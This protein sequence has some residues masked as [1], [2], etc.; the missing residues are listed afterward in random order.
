[1]LMQHLGK[2]NNPFPFSGSQKMVPELAKLC[3]QV[4]S[5]GSAV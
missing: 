3:F 5:I 4:G 2:L 1:M